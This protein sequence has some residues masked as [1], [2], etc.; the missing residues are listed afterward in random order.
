MQTSGT[1]SSYT[2][3]IHQPSQP[4]PFQHTVAA[5]APPP[6]PA[7]GQSAKMTPSKAALT[8]VITTKEKRV[9]VFLDFWF[10][11]MVF[12]FCKQVLFSKSLEEKVL[13]QI[14][15]HQIIFMH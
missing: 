6:P 4:N 15:I 14:T 3:D 7:N 5:P 12:L 2:E 11:A 9:T 10:F 13:S 1:N 8:L